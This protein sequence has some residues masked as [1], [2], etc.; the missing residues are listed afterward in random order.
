MPQIKIFKWKD[1]SVTYFE[2]GMLVKYI[3]QY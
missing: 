3:L 1:N 2:N